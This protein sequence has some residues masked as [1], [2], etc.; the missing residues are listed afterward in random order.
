[1]SETEKSYS[2]IQWFFL[3]IF[4][5]I[6]FTVILF[7]VILSL[8]GFNVV[9]KAKEFGANVQVVAD[10]FLEDDQVEEVDVALLE[11]T[12]LEKQAEVD[13]LHREIEQR[14]EEIA[15]LGS[16]K[17]Q[18]EQSQTVERELAAQA[19][20]E[21]DTIAKTYE[22]MSA[23]NAASIISALTDEEALLHLSQVS[24]DVRAAIL[25]KMESEKAADFMSRLAN[26]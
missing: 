4:I 13:R 3:V 12:I 18:L 5:P 22:A 15:R 26:Q 1:M 16:E 9:E 25:A 10:Y 19:Q 23:K 24:I 6:V 11:Q 17:A 21:L 2:K 14:D 8:L 7:S 20:Q